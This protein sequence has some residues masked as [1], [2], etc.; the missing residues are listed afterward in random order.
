MHEN[1]KFGYRFKVKDYDMGKR[2][3]F[4]V[5]NF[6]RG[7]NFTVGRGWG[8]GAIFRGNIPVSNFPGDNLPRGNFRS[9][10]CYLACTAILGSI[11][12]LFRHI[13]ALFKSIRMHIHP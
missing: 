9:T 10:K 13:R 11:S 1:I 12:G 2:G 7:G 3:N 8:G 4:A 6:S 5:D